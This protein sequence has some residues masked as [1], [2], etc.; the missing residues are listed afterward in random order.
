M[1]SNRK[2]IEQREN[3]PIRR[4]QESKRNPRV[5]AR[6]KNIKARRAM[7]REGQGR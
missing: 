3:D 5:K 4:P 6:D 1:T 2:A 7:K